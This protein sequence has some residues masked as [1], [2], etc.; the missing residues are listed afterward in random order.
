MLEQQ[1]PLFTVR[2]ILSSVLLRSQV[3]PRIRDLAVVSAVS[4]LLSVV[5]AFLAARIASRPLAR[6]SDLIDRISRGEVLADRGS[7]KNPAKE[8]AVVESKLSLLGEQMRDVQADRTQLQANVDQLL[9]VVRV[10]FDLQGFNH[11]ASDIILEVEYV[12]QVLVVVV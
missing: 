10:Q 7:S 2:V 12:R 6:I 11:L 3:M 4:L 1:A 9:G 8:V 5:L